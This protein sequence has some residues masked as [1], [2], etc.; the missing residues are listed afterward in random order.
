MGSSIS[1]LLTPVAY[2]KIRRDDKLLEELFIPLA[3][4]TLTIITIYLAGE[5]FSVFGSPGLIVSIVSYL[6]LLSGFYITALA[7]IATFNRDGMD[8][9]M[10]GDPPTLEMRNSLLPEK[11]SRRR[12]LCF[13]FGYLAFGSLM[14]YIGGT[15][16][17]LAAPILKSQL[18]TT[19]IVI[20]RWAIATI[21][22]FCTFNILIT[23]LLGMYY[24]TDRLHQ[25]PP[26]QSN[27]PLEIDY[28]SD[29]L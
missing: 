4:T 2:L 28:T 16:I 29:S 19:T 23:S 6:Q 17:T 18:D 13:L 7:A 9:P 5:K 1:R 8:D 24:L 22:I 26:A 10:L 3:L 14:L 27:V 15:I 12:F 20:L 21:Y 25:S 11:L